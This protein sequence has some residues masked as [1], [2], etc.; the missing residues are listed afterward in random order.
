MQYCPEEVV[1]RPSNSLIKEAYQTEEF[2]NAAMNDLRH[3]VARNILYLRRYRRMSQAALARAAETSQP[4]IA[5]IETAQEN[6]TLDTFERLIVALKGRCILA[7]PPAEIARSAPHC[8]WET[9]KQNTSAGTG[10]W[11]V[12]G[13]VTWRNDLTECA[14]V[15]LKRQSKHPG[16]A[17]ATTLLYPAKMLPP[18]ST[19]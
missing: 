11:T 10:A 7:V 14:I 15:G 8:W 3:H 19:T 12:M 6:I 17:T 4:A 9:L 16:V 18:A 2:K 13:S 1:S 5:R